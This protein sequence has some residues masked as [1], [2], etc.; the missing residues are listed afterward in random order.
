MGVRG[1]LAAGF[2]CFFSFSGVSDPPDRRISHC[3]IGDYEVCCTV[4]PLPF[5]RFLTLLEGL[6]VH[7]PRGKVLK[8]A[9]SRSEMSLNRHFR[10]LKWLKI[11]PWRAVYA[12]LFRP[13]IRAD[14]GSVGNIDDVVYNT[15]LEPGNRGEQVQAPPS[16]SQLFQPLPACARP[17]A[18][19]H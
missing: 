17:S 4:H 9:L 14:V 3:I 8:S 7:F 2:A 16:L 15:S 1:I 13:E 6:N 5:R 19:Y 11:A 18:S 10:K 12:P